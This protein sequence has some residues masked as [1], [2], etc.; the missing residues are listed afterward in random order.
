MHGPFSAQ[1]SH[2]HFRVFQNGI[3]HH[4]SDPLDFDDLDEV[5]YE[6]AMSACEIVRSMYGRVASDLDWRLEVSDPA[7]KIIYRFSFKAEKL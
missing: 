7:G 2:F 6:G 1:K 4:K 3:Q 5:W